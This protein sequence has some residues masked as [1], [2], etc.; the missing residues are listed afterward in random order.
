MRPKRAVNC[1]SRRDD[2]PGCR[3]LEELAADYVGVDAADYDAGS[4][5]GPRV[6]WGEGGYV[7]MSPAEVM[8]AIARD[9]SRA[10]G[11]APPPAAPIRAV[12]DAG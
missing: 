3:P 2:R 4:D 11:G 1:E 6:I 5:G 12:R 9:R 8:V 7:V 10:P